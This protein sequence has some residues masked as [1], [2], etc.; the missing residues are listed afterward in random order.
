VSESGMAVKKRVIVAMLSMSAAII[1]V[2][3]IRRRQKR[4]ISNR[5]KKKKEGS[6]NIGGKRITT[7][8]LTLRAIVL[9]HCVIHRMRV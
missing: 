7:P 6:I 1:F 5:R 4:E 9:L 2:G 3:F 8:L